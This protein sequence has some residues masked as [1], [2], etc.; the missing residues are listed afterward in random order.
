MSENFDYSI[1]LL[2]LSQIEEMEARKHDLDFQL[3]I[4]ERMM[5]N[6][7][8]LPFPFERAVILLNKNK[9]FDEAL[10]ICRY[11]EI[12]CIRAKQDWDGRSAK[13]W[14]SPSF[15]RCIERSKAIKQ[16]MKSC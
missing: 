9:R 14:L 16:K 5:Q 11:I 2:P 4:C 7:T 10:K 6:N 3:S 15:Q 12:Y 8:I 1:E 13:T